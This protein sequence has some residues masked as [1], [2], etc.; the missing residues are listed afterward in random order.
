MKCML[1]FY[2]AW[3]CNYIFFDSVWMVYADGDYCY[4][5]IGLLIKLMIDCAIMCE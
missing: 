2:Y 1:C 3:S 4:L 5:L